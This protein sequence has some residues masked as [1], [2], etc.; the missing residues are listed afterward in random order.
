ML[1]LND[2][3]TGQNPG[4]TVAIGTAMAEAGAV[5]LQSHNH[6]QGVQLTAFTTL[7]L[8]INE[9]AYSLAWNPIGDQARRGWNDI[10]DATEDAAAGIAVLLANREIGY[11]VIA[12]SRKGT[13]FDYLLGDADGLNVSDAELAVTLDWAKVLA[14]DRLVARGR[15]EVSGILEGND[16]VVAARVKEKLEQTNR[17]DHWAI[18]SF[19]IVVEFGRPLAEVRK[20]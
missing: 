14:D 19:A 11:M 18:P 5:C 6:Q 4:I 1:D 16:S 12:R 17:S 9:K 2:L 13:G 8:G 7:G 15:L 10:A 3:G 20:K